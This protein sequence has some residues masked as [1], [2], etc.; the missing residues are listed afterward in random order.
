M[1]R[2]PRANAH[3]LVDIELDTT[4]EFK[5]LRD[6]G[7]NAFRDLSND[8]AELAEDLQERLGNMPT[9]PGTRSRKVLGANLDATVRARIVAGYLKTAAELLAKVGWLFSKTYAAFLKHFV[10]EVEAARRR[11][12]AKSMEITEV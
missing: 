9:K 11:D 3:T 2:N 4:A 6:R 12:P 7:K 10:D 5:Q 1:A 8:V